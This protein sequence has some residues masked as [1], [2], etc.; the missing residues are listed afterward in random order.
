MSFA[1]HETSTDDGEPISLYL[2]RYGEPDAAVFGYTDAEQDVVGPGDRPGLT[3][4][5]K[6]ASIDCDEITASGTLDRSTTE[7]RT[8]DDTELAD[9][10]RLYP[11]SSIV[12]VSIR[13][14]HANDEDGQFLAVWA[15]RVLGFSTEDNEATYTCQPI[16]TSL[17]R[18]GLRRRWQLGC[19]HVLYGP[20]CKASKPAATTNH[21]VAAVLGA[22]VTLSSGWATDARKL[23]H[24]GG[25]AEWTLPDGRREVRTILRTDP[26]G[27]ITLGG[28]AYGLED[29]MTISLSL[30][31]N[32]QAGVGP[33]PDG[34]CLPLHNNIR[35][36]GGCM[37]IP[38]KNP[39]GIKNI[40][41]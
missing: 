26:S 19:P 18:I 9:L 16:S 33:Q 6:A 29:G 20:K 32:H 38:T 21:V 31:C 24:H 3:V 30:G 11:P 5:Y 35:N 15:G 4:T 8:S 40:F 14:G 36:F 17:K 28:Y 10:F 7:I 34:D 23:K 1:E 12:T 39:V 2:F 27:T 41:Y 13:E 25:L 37:W 22:V